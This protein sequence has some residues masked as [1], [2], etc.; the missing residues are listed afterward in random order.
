MVIPY[1]HFRS[2]SPRI[3]FLVHA[4]YD[5][6]PGLLC[7][8]IDRVTLRCS[9]T[10]AWT[11]SQQLVPLSWLYFISPSAVCQAVNGK[12]KFTVGL[13]PPPH[14]HYS[15]DC[16]LQAT[17]GC[18]H[19]KVHH[20]GIKFSGHCRRLLWNRSYK[21]FQQLQN[22]RAVCIDNWGLLCR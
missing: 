19:I 5:S 11:L 14:L 2:S 16:W 8:S 10:M 3:G 6:Q 20:E 1:Q 18:F 13:D 17:S 21:C 7:G 4:S 22:H 12:K 9:Q 15:L